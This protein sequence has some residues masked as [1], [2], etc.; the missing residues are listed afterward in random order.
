MP[1]TA[2]SNSIYIDYETVSGSDV[3]SS[4]IVVMGANTTSAERRFRFYIN[5]FRGDGYDDKQVLTF[6]LVQQPKQ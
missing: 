1:T 4:L 3:P 6:D 2:Q 5:A